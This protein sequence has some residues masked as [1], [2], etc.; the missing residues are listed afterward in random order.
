[1]TRVFAS[2]VVAAVAM[3]LS[4][5]ASMSGLDATDTYGCK[6]PEG[7]SCI[8]VSGTYANSNPGGRLSRGPSA[9]AK[10]PGE[11][12][13]VYGAASVALAPTSA[14][15]S[16]SDAIRSNPRLL[17][18][19]IAP[20]ED[21]DGD[22][23]EEGYVHMVVDNGRWLIE[24]VRPAA[25]S[26]V[27]GVAPPAAPAADASPSKPEAEPISPAQRLPVPP[28]SADSSPIDATP[29]ER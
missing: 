7:V 1:M 14:P 3:A 4:G 10:S 17:R 25:R 19:W 6:A 13:A 5:C 29:I 11:G 2:A 27:D 24:H 28:P 21:S 23:H 22:L 16:T 20:W 18:V 15:G 8:S 9:P 12:P 26:N